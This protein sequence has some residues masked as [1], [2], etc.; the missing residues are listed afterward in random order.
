MNQLLVLNVTSFDL[1]AQTKMGPQLSSD[2]CNYDLSSCL[3]NANLSPSDYISK[4]LHLTKDG[5]LIC[6]TIRQGVCQ[7]RSY[8]D[9]SV[10]RNG[11]VPVSPNSVSASC[12][13]LIDS[14]G[15]LFVASTYAVD[16]PYRYFF[17]RLL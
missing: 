8:H 2:L 14:E 12:V 3:S 4:I 16:T 6:G 1:I 9:L 7:I 13:S 15:M 11:S 5:I 10:I 17:I